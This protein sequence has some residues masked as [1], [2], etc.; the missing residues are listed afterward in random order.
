MINLIKLCYYRS[1]IKARVRAKSVYHPI[2]SLQ[3]GR[4]SRYLKSSS[5]LLNIYLRT[6]NWQRT[7]SY[8]GGNWIFY[9]RHYSGWWIRSMEWSWNQYGRN[10]DAR[11][12]LQSW[13]AIFTAKWSKGR[14]CPLLQ[15]LWYNHSM[16]RMSN[17]SPIPTDSLH[18]SP[19]QSIWM[20]WDYAGFVTPI[21]LALNSKYYLS[22]NVYWLDSNVTI[23]EWSSNAYPT[24]FLPSQVCHVHELHSWKICKPLTEMERVPLEKCWEN[25]GDR[26]FASA[27]KVERDFLWKPNRFVWFKSHTGKTGQFGASARLSLPILQWDAKPNLVINFICTSGDF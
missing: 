21:D 25:S 20:R 1:G 24:P 22:N 7:Q 4:S 9:K 6:L 17:G 2:R 8:A 26:Y 11:N 23:M 19:K 12:T 14:I 27:V 16:R 15:V 13:R 5:T 18:T 10:Q 3:H